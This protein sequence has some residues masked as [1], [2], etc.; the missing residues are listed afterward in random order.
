MTLEPYLEFAKK[1]FA[2]EATYRLEVFTEIGPLIV[3]VYLLRS[4]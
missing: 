2:R 1:A 3:R 4:V